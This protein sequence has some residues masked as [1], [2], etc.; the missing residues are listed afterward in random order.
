MGGYQTP[1]EPSLVPH[2]VGSGLVL[3]PVGSSW[4]GQPNTSSPPLSLSL[5]K[6]D[7]SAETFFY[8][9]QTQTATNVVTFKRIGIPN[10][11]L[12]YSPLPNHAAHKSRAHMST[13]PDVYH[14]IGRAIKSAKITTSRPRA[15]GRIPM[16]SLWPACPRIAPHPG[17]PSPS[18]HPVLNP[19]Q[20]HHIAQHKRNWWHALKRHRHATHRPCSSV[21]ITLRHSHGRRSCSTP[22]LSGGCRRCRTPHALRVELGAADTAELAWVAV[23]GLVD[24]VRR[25]A[26]AATVLLHALP[27]AA[28]RVLFGTFISGYSGNFNHMGLATSRGN[29]LRAW[30]LSLMTRST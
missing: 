15:T 24:H 22:P 18:G 19:P 9:Y 6:K 14:R 26:P 5:S 11:I 10:I 8:V 21:S 23:L 7:Q 30:R 2:P 4:T 16:R 20:E 29:G 17:A 3:A 28:R 13:H 1:A 27:K 12:H 25:R